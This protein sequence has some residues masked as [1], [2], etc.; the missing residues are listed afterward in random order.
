MFSHLHVPH[1]LFLLNLN[2][3]AMFQSHKDISPNGFMVVR[4][5][6]FKFSLRSNVSCMWVLV[7]LPQLHPTNMTGYIHERISIDS[8]FLSDF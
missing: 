7:E 5:D 2:N 8:V 1:P 3:E 6:L 4:F